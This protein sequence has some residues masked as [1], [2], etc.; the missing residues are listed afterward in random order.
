MSPPRF[1][2]GTLA[3]A[4]AAIA[5]PDTLRLE[6]EPLPASA[7]AT[8]VE[9]RSGEHVFTDPDWYT[10]CP[11]VIRDA[12][13]HYQLFH[14]RWPKAKG[15][16]AWLTHSEIR[17]A[18]ADR[19]EGPYRPLG[20]VIP[21]V[22][23]GRGRWFN[24]HNPKVERFEGAYWL[25]FIQTWAKDGSEAARTELASLGGRHPA[26][27]GEVRPNQRTFVAKAAA[28]DGPWSV[29]PDPVVEPAK[30]IVRLT[31]NPA[32][33][34]R[35]GGGYLMIVKGDKPG[36]TQFIRNQA[37]ATAPRPEGPWTIADRA[38]IDDLDTEDVSLWHDDRRGRY[39]A[40]FHT[41]KG[42]GFIGMITS[43][44]GL[45]WTRA[46]QFELTPK[47]LRF[48]DGESFKPSM[49]E[50]PYVLRD[51][52]G[53]PSHLLVAVGRPGGSSIVILPLRATDGR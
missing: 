45:A 53:E 6:V 48:D 46:A 23:E 4:A 25:Y 24:A 37:V 14:S 47:I 27:L 7:R 8:L 42:K 29:A 1:A 39:Y 21:A 19:P 34:A 36:T 49:M 51:E 3:L 22:G 44:D 20:T 18:V 50:R 41:T 26:W 5:G 9:G 15:W 11:S 16:H 17:R 30:T 35:P 32:V 38:A 12:D 33:C 28:L 13:G 43:E 52:S 10:W 2:L 40:V 31:V